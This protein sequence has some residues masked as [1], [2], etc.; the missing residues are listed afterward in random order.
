[1]LKKKKNLKLVKVEK[2]YEGSFVFPDP[3]DRT[4]GIPKGVFYSDYP[5]AILYDAAGN[6]V[7][8]YK[9]VKRREELKESEDRPMDRLLDKSEKFSI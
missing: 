6:P 9:E 3:K 4:Y 8:N 1:M 2:G 5:P 7:N